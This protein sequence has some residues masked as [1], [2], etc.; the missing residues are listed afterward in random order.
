[1]KKPILYVVERRMKRK[2]AQW[3]PLSGY[4]ADDKTQACYHLDDAQ[5]D[6]APPPAE[7]RIATYARVS[8]R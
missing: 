8:P 2:C 6:M 3:Q 1:M 4:V 7:F 5:D